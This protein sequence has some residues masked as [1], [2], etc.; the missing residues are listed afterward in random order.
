M[1]AAAARY[2]KRKSVDEQIGRMRFCET[3]PRVQYRFAGQ[4]ID[5]L[6]FK[7]RQPR[8]YRPELFQWDSGELPGHSG[9]I[10]L[11]KR[12]AQLRARTQKKLR[13]RKHDTWL[14]RVKRCA[15][16]RLNR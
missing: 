11:Q 5:L 3:C 14:F 13:G 9:S 15:P 4:G 8:L 2:R 16:S 12:K 10:D 6:P 7:L 1:Q